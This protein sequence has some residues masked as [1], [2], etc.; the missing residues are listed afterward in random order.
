MPVNHII[1]R[2]FENKCK[3]QTFLHFLRGSHFIFSDNEIILQ[4]SLFSPIIMNFTTKL[5]TL[6]H[7]MKALTFWQTSAPVSSCNLES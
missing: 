2:I 4:E 3:S 1:N 6:P 5:D 7:V